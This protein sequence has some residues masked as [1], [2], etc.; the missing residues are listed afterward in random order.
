M[1]TFFRLVQ[2]RWAASAMSGDGARLAG[3]RWNPRG[4]AAVYLA[5]SRA[6]AALEIMVHA[7]RESLQLEW[8]LFEVEVPGDCIQQADPA[9]LPPDW[10]RLP[11]SPLAQ[12]YGEAW[13]RSGQ[14]LA[15]RL[16]SVIIPQE[17][18]LLLHPDH[19][20]RSRLRVTGPL[21]FPFDTRL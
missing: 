19:P 21:P 16:P 17:S 9:D 4:R 18:T 20:A 6:L 1:A 15:L 14:A 5:E 8:R 13:L 12:R 10:R 11:Q 7:P 3:G 2:A